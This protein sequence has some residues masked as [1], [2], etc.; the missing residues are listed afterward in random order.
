MKRYNANVI[1]QTGV[2]VIC[3]EYEKRYYSSRW[4]KQGKRG[5]RRNV[6]RVLRMWGPVH[7]GDVRP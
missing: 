5:R 6:R 4:G 2:E 3:D 1:N 7:E